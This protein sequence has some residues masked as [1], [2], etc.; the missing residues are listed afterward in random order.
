MCI[1]LLPTCMYGHHICSWYLQR[2][3][4][5]RS[6]RTAVADGSELPCGC[7]ELKQGP[8]QVEE[9]LLIVKPS[10]QSLI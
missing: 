4:G 3:E 2:S 6:P 10:L 5:I 8:L 7:Q 1:S 9:V